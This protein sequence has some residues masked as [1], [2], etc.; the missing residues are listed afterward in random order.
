M[1]KGKLL[2]LF[3]LVV[4]LSAC[5][6]GTS[7]EDEEVQEKSERILSDDVQT[8][9]TLSD[10]A[11]SG[12]GEA[13]RIRLEIRK[14]NGSPIEDFD[15]NHEKLL[16]LMVISKDL[17]Y[18][19]HLHPEYKGRGVFEIDN[20]FPAG[21]EYRLI[22]D[23]KPANGDA[24]TKMEWVRVPGKRIDPPPVIPDAHLDKTVDG[25]R[26]K[27]AI[28]PIGANEETTFTFTLSDEVSDKPIRDLQPYLGSIGHVVV[29]SEDGQRYVHVHAEEEQGA[30][31][32]AVF[33]TSFPG[34]GVYK[35]WGQFQRNNRVFTVDYVV[36]VP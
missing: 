4:F 27:L 9:W 16:H 29:L 35:I 15:I 32:K 13:R 36:R 26:V 33:E 14:R 20:D 31:P 28:D 1:S 19:R 12:A 2:V 11:A 34:S 30:G 10:G 6:S 17:S 7:W 8:V 3:I 25:I 5:A 22:A 21:G 23:F 18:F 24:M